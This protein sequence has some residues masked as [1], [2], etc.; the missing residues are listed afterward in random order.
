MSQEKVDRYKKEKA[1]RKKIMAKEKF[2]HRLAVLCSC[3]VLVAIL[4][5]AGYSVYG[6]YEKNKPTVTTYANLD[7]LNNYLSTLSSEN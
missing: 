6:I 7:S 3:L 5:W 4:G 1:N 2:Q